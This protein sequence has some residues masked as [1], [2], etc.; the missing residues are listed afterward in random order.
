MIREIKREDKVKLENILFRTNNFSDEE[1]KIA[2]ELINNAVEN[3]NK[4]DYFIKVLGEDN[5]LRGYYC[6]GK[7]AL[8]EGVFDLYWIVVDPHFAGNG[9]GSLLL[10]DAEKEVKHRNGKLILAETSSRKDYDLTREFYK[11][12]NYQEL[13]VI[14]DFYKKND[15]LI[16][17]G[18][19][20]S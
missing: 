8:T 16:I 18:K 11:K 10:K 17:F 20:L 3:D 4:G 15:S 19:Y 7:R 14:K 6:I 2:I 5:E 1:R 12:N 13:A 9:F